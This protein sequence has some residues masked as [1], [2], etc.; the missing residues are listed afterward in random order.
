MNTCNPLNSK[1]AVGSDQDI[2]IVKF[3]LK[4]LNRKKDNMSPSA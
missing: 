4:S 3:N 1:L 2:K